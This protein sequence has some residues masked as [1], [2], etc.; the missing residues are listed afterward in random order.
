MAVSQIEKRLTVRIPALAGANCCCV[1]GQDTFPTLSLYECVCWLVVGGLSVY[2][3][4][5]VILSILV[6]FIVILMC[7]VVFLLLLV[8]LVYELCAVLWK[9]SLFMKCAI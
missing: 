4:F 3:F 5:F 7:F 9:Q 6:Y 8:Y 1:L 2:L